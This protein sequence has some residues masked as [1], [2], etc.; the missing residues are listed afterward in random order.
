MP[1]LQWKPEYTV[2]KA[3][4]DS[5]HIWLFNALNSAYENV[6]NSSGVTS[7]VSVVDELSEYM[8]LHFLAEEQLMHE[9]GYDG[10]DAHIAEHRLFTK[11]IEM[12]K[13]NHHDNNLEAAKEL[14]IVLG[15]WIL[16]HILVEDKKY[17][18]LLRQEAS[19]RPEVQ[20]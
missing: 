16:R 17:S 4:L 2:N 8:K 5:H 1:L 18:A 12:L 7:I 13:A 15:N 11:N 10:I 19:M 6:M 9:N 14:I 20:L 3:E